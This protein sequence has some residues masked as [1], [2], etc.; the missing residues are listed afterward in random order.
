MNQQ[1]G[2]LLESG[3]NE[4]EVLE[5]LISGQ[6][7]GVNVLKIKQIISYDPD[8]VAVLH[9]PEIH[10]SIKGT[11][12]FHDVP[13]LLTDL[14]RYLF[15]DRE[16]IRS[17]TPQVVVV[18]EFNN[19]QQGFLIDAVDRIFR[20]NWD[21]I[22]APT[23]IIA[24][25]DAMVTGIVHSEGHDVLLIDFEA[26]IN[27][28]SGGSTLDPTEDGGEI[29]AEERAQ[30]SLLKVLLADDSQLVREQTE[31]L[32]R[33]AGFSDLTI[34]ED[35]AE[36]YRAIQSNLEHPFDVVISDIEMPQLDGLT[37]CRKLKEMKSPTKVIILSSMISEQVSIMC[38]QVGA[39]GF[40]SK[41]QMR[42]LPHIVADQAGT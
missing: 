35:G 14:N 33:Q 7:F 39:D 20:C 16:P 9:A 4:L 21:Q 19:A 40:L 31:H 22:Q 26:I 41:G 5:L 18:C 2:I 34:C 32:M 28:I 17:E 6:I 23:S 36:A 37:L 30:R 12:L 10:P 8:K 25:S 11:F 29:S 24:E 15:P 1:S 27:D 13:I 3:T 38:R 42:E